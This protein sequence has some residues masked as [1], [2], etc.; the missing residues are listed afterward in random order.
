VREPAVRPDR[1]ESGRPR[2]DGVEGS[3]PLAARQD[4]RPDARQDV[5]QDGVEGSRPLAARRD[6]VEGSRP[7]PARPDTRQDGVEGSRPMVARQDT[8]QDAS[9]DNRRNG[10]EGSR[11]MPANGRPPVG[12][13]RMPQQPYLRG[14]R[15]QGPPPPMRFGQ[16]AGQPGPRGPQNQP[17]QPVGSP[18]GQFPAA[19]NGEQP[20]PP[21]RSRHRPAPPPP[22]ATPSD[23][24][25]LA[26][27][28]PLP[29]PSSVGE[30]SESRGFPAQPEAP[31]ERAAPALSRAERRGNGAPARS[32]RAAVAA[33]RDAEAESPI[34]AEMASAWF[35]EN[36]EGGGRPGRD[37][38]HGADSGDSD[39][40]W[41]AG[42]SVLQPMPDAVES[43]LT[44]AGLPKRRPRSNL[45]P[46]GPSEDGGNTPPGIPARSAEQ[47][48]GRL[49]SYQQ[50]V[51]QGRESRHR[52]TT[53]TASTGGRQMQENFGEENP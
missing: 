13:R 8:G 26:P 36:W 2:Q 12:G 21:P 22:P 51:R 46:G 6:A 35:R 33:G 42:D 44:T 25:Q 29:S 52:R 28:S 23:S 43:E 1:G 3:R 18:S 39:E 24:A 53:E 17:G 4:A 38:S 37:G 10:V 15:G 27:A 5:R 20:P 49:A 9:P 34:F 32:G 41:A 31:A 40:T 7:M 47:V 48:R 45:I 16:P 30:P 14:P 50:G 19:P 11:P